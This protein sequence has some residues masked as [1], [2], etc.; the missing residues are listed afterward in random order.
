MSRFSAVNTRPI[1]FRLVIV[2]QKYVKSAIL[3]MEIYDAG[4]EG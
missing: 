2:L 4:K 3:D 1:I